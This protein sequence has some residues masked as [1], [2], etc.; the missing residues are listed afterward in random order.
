MFVKTF[1]YNKFDVIGK[2]VSM[3]MPDYIAQPHN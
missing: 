3:L 1:G 2:N